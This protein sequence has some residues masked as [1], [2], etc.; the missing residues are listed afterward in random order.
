MSKVFFQNDYGEGAHPLVMQRL[1]ETN[2]EHTCGYGLDEYSLKAAQLILDKVGNPN[3]QVHMMAG[4]TSANAIALS[5]FM[6]PFEAVVCAPTGHINVH[7][8]GAVEATGHKVLACDSEN[9]KALPEG[10]RRVCLLHGD[11]HMVHPRVLY[12][13]QS[14]EIGTAY[15]LAELKALRAV[16]DEFGLY[17]Y[18]DGARLGSALAAKDCDVTLRDLGELADAFYIGGTKNG[19]LFGEAMVVCNPALQPHFRYMIKNRG[20]MMA[21]GR[22]CGV[23]FLTAFENDDYFAWAAHANAMAD[24]IRE[25]MA[26]A[27]I[28]QFV[29]TTGNQVFPVLTKA[30]RDR[31]AEEFAFERWED[32]DEEMCVIR[33]VTSWATAVEDVRRLAGALE[34]L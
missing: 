13:S 8:T 26:A 11:E 30:Q 5:A 6:R 1:L 29:R 12:I 31:L 34:A 14:T 7:E 19:L 10:V 24:I 32:L 23:M 33:F 21:K 25:A 22:L 3:A 2:M 20:G 28:A 27:G 18:I 17:L 16:C 4:G 15:T 9:G